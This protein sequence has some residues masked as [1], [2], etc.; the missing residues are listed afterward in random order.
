VIL[1]ITGEPSQ[2]RNNLQ[3][4]KFMIPPGIS[5]D[6]IAERLQ[7]I[8]QELHH[9][10]EERLIELL[11]LAGFKPPL[12]FFQSAIYMGWIVKKK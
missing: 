3:V 4:L 5:Q 1:D 8:E 10:P 12:R 11:A 7:R 2:I 6:E 9:V